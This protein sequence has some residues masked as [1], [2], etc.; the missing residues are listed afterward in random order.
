MAALAGCEVGPN[1]VRPQMDVPDKFTEAGPWKEGVPQETIARGDWWTMFSDP[2]LDALQARAVRQNPDVKAVAA[3]VLQAQASAGIARSYLYPTLAGGVIA[4]RYANNTNFATL[5]DPATVTEN[6]PTIT[7]AYKAVPIYTA[8]EIDFWGS[9]RR[10]SE[11]AQAELGASIATYHTAMLTL[12]G[13]VAQTYFQVRTSDELLRIL[14]ED[15]ELHRNT[16]NLINARQTDGLSNDLA[17]A[18]TQTALT[19]SQA[20]AEA[21]KAQR[22]TLVNKL[23][24]LT[25]TNPEGF[26]VER[27]PQRSERPIPAVPVGLPSDLL[28]RR[29]DIARAE[30]EMAA[31]N[32]QIGVAI[33][34]Y[35]PQIVLTSSVGFES[36]ALSA[37]TNPMSN[38]WGIA[39]SL[40]QQIFNAGR[41]S[42]NVEK[43]RASYEERVALY[44]AALLRGFQDVETALANLRLL[45]EQ[46]RYQQAAVAS[47]N[48]TALLMAQRF[49]HGLVSMLD[50]LIAQ[51]AA[52]ASQTVAVQIAN[53]QLVTTV[54]LVKAL[55][56][57]WQDRPQQLP[58][59]VRSM[60]APPLKQ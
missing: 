7:N 30:R 56:G 5:V 38:I 20:Q 32:A 9:V 16:F 21:V 27:R 10:Q 51:R 46:A 49:Q 40:F 14:N 34:A 1:Y 48:R 60:W 36:Y 15:I 50:V 25:G 42:L 22:A 17:V 12:N 55:G 39:F 11:S 59:G 2:E 33:A 24:I 4:Q 52:L 53:E 3:R 57:G 13:D 28:Q 35:F 31:A 23:A 6:T 44:Q 41:I 54:A 37:L 19:T 18:E 43:T 8:Y 26:A 45:S 58:E 29:P 47:A